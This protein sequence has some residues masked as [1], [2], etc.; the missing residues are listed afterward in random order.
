MDFGIGTSV[1]AKSPRLALTA[2]TAVALTLLLTA[3][4]SSTSKKS[5]A[6]TTTLSQPSTS[7]PPTLP[8]N[9]LVPNVIGQSYQSAAYAALSDVSLLSDYRSEHSST[10]PAGTVIAQ[11]PPAGSKV[12]SGSIVTLVVS[13]GPAPPPGTPP[14][15]A[16]ALKIEWGSPGSEET[17]Q[18]TADWSFTNLAKPCF[19]KGYPVISALDTQGRLLGFTYSHY[20]DQ[21]TTDAAPQP[22][23]LPKGNS[24]WIRLNKYRCDI[25]TQDKTASFRLAMPAES[26]TLNVS[27]SGGF[28][29]CQ[30]APSL[31]IAVS[32]FEPIETLLV[33]PTAA[34]QPYG[35]VESLT[36]GNDGSVTPLECGN[37]QL[38]DA[39][40]QYF[41]GD[42]QGG[43][44][45]TMLQLPPSATRTQVVDAMCHDVAPGQPAPSGVQTEQ[46][47][48]QLAA[49]L[50]GW[51][52]GLNVVREDSACG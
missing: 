18:N 36:L 29:Y 3:C 23:Y 41:E 39:A 15:Q 11:T 47:V 44:Y 4:T 31:I 52:Y 32:P 17:G 25:A 30:E 26:G 7:T 34:G 22:V 2:L 42:N 19:L 12:P 8:A 21:M 6:T 33:A 20:G 10:L 37:G 45:P 9:V 48:Y 35:C 46:Q 43:W 38:N 27:V 14:C 28:D 51:Q 13:V 5:A 49:K 1:A 40:L 24:A 16:A 50:N